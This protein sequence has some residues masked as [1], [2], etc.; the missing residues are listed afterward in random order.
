MGTGPLKRLLEFFERLSP[1]SDEERAAIEASAVVKQ[2]AE[3]DRLPVGTQTYFVLE[4][5]V[6]QL[7]R[8]EDGEELTVGL[9]TEGQ[10]IVDST[11]E[12]FALEDTQVIVGDD[13]K[14]A[15][16]FARFPRLESVARLTLQQVLAEA[17]A[18]AAAHRTATPEERYQS[19]APELLQRVPQ[20]VLASYLGVTPESLSRIRKRLATRARGT[21]SQS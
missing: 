1:L 9:F 5:C 7:H 3:G 15:Q 4:G 14:Q 19:L 8:T 10:W 6:R 2:F 16:L 17:N 11:Y 20:Y 18:A 21:R 12:L 13:T